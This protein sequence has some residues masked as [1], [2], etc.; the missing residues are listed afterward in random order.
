[1][2]HTVLDAAYAGGVRYFDVARSYGESR[3]LSGRLVAGP[4]PRPSD[5]TVGSKWGYTYT[6]DWRLDA[7]V[8]E[9]KDLSLPNLRRQFAESSG[10]LG[11]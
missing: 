11:P 9:V 8:N 10:L 7:P 3:G 4:G 5:V 6:A 1:M 2:T